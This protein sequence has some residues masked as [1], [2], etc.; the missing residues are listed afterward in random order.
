MQ[1]IDS[2]LF[3]PFD[4]YHVLLLYRSSLWPIIIIDRYFK[5]MYKIDYIIKCKRRNFEHMT[6]MFIFQKEK[7]RTQGQQWTIVINETTGNFTSLR[8]KERKIG[9]NVFR[10][11]KV[12]QENKI[13]SCLYFRVTLS[14]K[15]KNEKIFY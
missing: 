13:D 2:F 12:I 7:E 1:S 6:R 10:K 15:Q 4:F 11:K 14:N 8:P 3:L 5:Y 9:E